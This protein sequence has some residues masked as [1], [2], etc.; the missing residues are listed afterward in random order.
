MAKLSKCTRD[1]ISC[2]QSLKV[3]LK[4]VC[5]DPCENQSIPTFN[6]TFTGGAGDQNFYRIL[7]SA[8]WARGFTSHTLESVG[9]GLYINQSL[10]KGTFHR[11]QTVVYPE[12]RSVILHY[13]FILNTIT[14]QVKITKTKITTRVVGLLVTTIP[15]L[16][17]EYLGSSNKY[18]SVQRVSSAFH[19]WCIAS[20]YMH[21]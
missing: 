18:L 6:L 1:S 14:I 11:E 7:A 17:G 2:N 4:Q 16:Q 13:S 19:I 15:L 8:I 20:K 21:L 10:P 3:M 9:S 12:W 5:P